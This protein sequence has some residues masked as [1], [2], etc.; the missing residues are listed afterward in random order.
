MSDALVPMAAGWGVAEIDFLL[1]NKLID[2]TPSDRRFELAKRVEVRIVL[3]HGSTTDIPKTDDEQT[4]YLMVA[5][6]LQCAVNL[7]VEAARAKP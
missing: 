5:G 4:A 7:L 3:E 2:A 6:S 1:D